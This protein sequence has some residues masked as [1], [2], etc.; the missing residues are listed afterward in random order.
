VDTIGGYLA[1]EHKC[2][3]EAFVL[4][5]NTVAKGDWKQ[6]EES[7]RQFRQSL[8]G[9]LRKE[10]TVLFPEMEALTGSQTGPTSV[11]R[12]EHH[13]MRRLMEAMERDI[14]GRNADHYLGLSETLLILIQQHNSKEEHILYRM[15]DMALAGSRGKI[16]D[17]MRAMDGWG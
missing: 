7:F 14:D 9:H 5:E 12:M 2:C 10:E 6:A 8:E 11:M 16:L 17:R 4:A 13:D 1:L 3:D 15:A